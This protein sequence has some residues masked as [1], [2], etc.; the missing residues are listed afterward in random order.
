MMFDARDVHRHHATGLWKCRTENL[1]TIRRRHPQE[2]GAVGSPENFAAEIL[3]T[4]PRVCRFTCPEK[5]S[6]YNKGLWVAVQEIFELAVRLA[7]IRL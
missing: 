7:K 3:Q 5:K 2:N 1:G 6:M 4:V